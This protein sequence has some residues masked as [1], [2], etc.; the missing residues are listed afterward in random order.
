MSIPIDFIED[1]KRLGY[2]E[3]GWDKL[4][5]EWD[6][7]ERDVTLLA[8]QSGMVVRL[9][10]RR[11]WGYREDE[12]YLLA[13]ATNPGDD[14]MNLWAQAFQRLEAIFGRSE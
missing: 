1:A 6:Q 14:P 10:G 4:E 12:E 9:E 13:A 8:A 3:G 2:G 11:V 7:W 5:A